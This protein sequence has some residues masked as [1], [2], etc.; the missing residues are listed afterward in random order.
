MLYSEDIDCLIIFNYPLLTFKLLRRKQ[1]GPPKG[2]C[3][4]HKTESGGSLILLK[5]HNFGEI[6]FLEFFFQEKFLGGKKFYWQI[7]W[8]NFFYCKFFFANFFVGWNLIFWLHFFLRYF[9]VKNF[10]WKNLFLL[11]FFFLLFFC[12]IFIF[13]NFFSVKIYS[14]GNSWNMFKMVPGT[15]LWSL[16][17][18]G[19]V[20]SQILLIWTDITRTNIAW[21]D[22]I[23]T[24][25][26]CL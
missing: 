9:F 14:F 20:R 1:D 16:V 12:K 10:F 13:G 8:G 5:G 21:T 4:R 3:N 18:I 2:N 23:V 11:K 22:V 6:F 15:Y 24:V 26:I 25:E 17:E 19:S 7:F